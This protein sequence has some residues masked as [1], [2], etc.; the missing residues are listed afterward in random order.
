MY[1]YF[2]GNKLLGSSSYPPLWRDHE[3]S[4]HSLAFLCPEC[5]TVWGRIIMP[6][7]EW[8]PLRTY[9]EAH[10]KADM[11]GSFLLSWVRSLDHL[12]T[13]VLVY[14]ANLLFRKSTEY[15]L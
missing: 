2:L 8:L 14:E 5:G 3:V 6:G 13:E 1:L 9:C 12:P 10:P 15:N 4:S 11:A 7:G